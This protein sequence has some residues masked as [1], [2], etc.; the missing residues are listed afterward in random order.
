MKGN[1]WIE[2]E[3]RENQPS[4]SGCLGN[5]QP[6]V[7]VI[8]RNLWGKAHEPWDLVHCWQWTFSSPRSPH[9]GEVWVWPKFFFLLLECLGPLSTVNNW[10][11]LSWQLTHRNSLL[12][13]LLA[14]TFLKPLTML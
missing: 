7:L 12:V 9:P 13:L 14:S 6:Q 5:L 3:R 8:M 11:P 10:R 4:W 1:E 2:V